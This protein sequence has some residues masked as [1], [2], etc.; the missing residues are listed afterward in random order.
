MIKNIDEW[1]RQRAE[2][3]SQTKTRTPT[4]LPQQVR[5]LYRATGSRGARKAIKANYIQNAAQ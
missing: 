2:L 1:L 3:N 5:E 4:L